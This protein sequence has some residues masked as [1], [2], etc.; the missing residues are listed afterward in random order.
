M[1]NTAWEDGI[2][3]ARS[4]LV[5]I[6]DPGGE[7]LNAL[8]QATGS[9]DAGRSA[10]ERLIE[11][12]A[13]MLATNRLLFVIAALIGVAALSVWLAPRPTHVVDPSQAH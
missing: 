4:D 6:S 10:F 2:K 13:A 12:Q 7:I 8:T 3:S 9:P 5:A 1:V 11:V